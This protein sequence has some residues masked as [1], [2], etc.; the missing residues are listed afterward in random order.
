MD[1]L[2]TQGEAGT[3]G[4]SGWQFWID[5]GGTFTDVVARAPDG[6]LLVHK[7]LSE[8]PER[9]KDAS[10]QGIRDMLGIDKAQPIPAHLV[11]AVKMGTTVAT[12]AL[13]ERKG[14][15]TVFVTTAGF[16][17]ALRIA[18]QNRP[19][20]FATRIVLL[21]MLY[22]DV[23]EVDERFSADG[24]ELSPVDAQPLRASLE[25]AY[26][27]GIRSCAIAFMHSYR[28]PAHERLVAG[29]AAEVGFSHISLSH[30]TSP[31]MK[32]V[33]RAD[34][35]VADA[36]LSPILGRYVKT[37]AAELGQTRLMFMQSS[38]GLADAQH[39]HGKDSILSGPAA[40]IVGAAKT[41]SMAG[42]SKII[43][44]DMG[45]TSTDVAHFQGEYERSFETEIA[46][47]RLRAPFMSIH[48]VAAGGGS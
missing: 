2:E 23:I 35:T 32:L 19:E 26:R 22:E 15:R 11:S 34:T 48:T 16:A 9:Y 38:G 30:E 12:N 20:I 21:E 36:Y 31:L 14:E 47:V 6:R 29:I 28:Y 43:S 42:F 8:A 24:Q 18:Y 41:S 45:G 10:V 46:G 7:L 27:S 1:K 44:F 33:S 40:G 3:G 17:D 25:R 39:F 13:L 37:V 4:D 5:R